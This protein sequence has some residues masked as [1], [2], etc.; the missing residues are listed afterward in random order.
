MMSR[1][2]KLLFC[3]ITKVAEGD[4]NVLCSGS[5]LQVPFFSLEYSEIEIRLSF[6]F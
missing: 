1:N 3:K 6:F 4:I 2:G 5:R